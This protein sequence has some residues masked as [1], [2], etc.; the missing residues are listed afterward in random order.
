M[1]N[2]FQEEAMNKG[3]DRSFYLTCYV[4][5]TSLACWIVSPPGTNLLV[6]SPVNTHRMWPLNAQVY[7]YSRL[8]HYLHCPL[9][10][11]H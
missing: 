2:F 5:A 11:R 7:I 4:T 3:L 6:P 10:L 8:Y 9:P 1:P